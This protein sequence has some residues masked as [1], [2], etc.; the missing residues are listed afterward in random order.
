MADRQTSI[1]RFIGEVE[2]QVGLGRATEPTHYP[3]LKELMEALKSNIT[4]T[5]NPKRVECGAPDFVIDRGNIT[6]GYVEAKK[7]GTSLD[8]IEKSEQLLRYRHSLSNL[9][10]TDFLEFRRYVDGEKRGTARLG[11]IGI[12]G[13]VKQD[14]SGG[15][16]VVE[17]LARFLDEPAVVVGT[18]KELAERMARLTHMIREL[19][20]A[21]FDNETEAGH[22]HGQLAAFQENLIPDLAKVPFSDMYAQTMAYG[23]FAA[24]ATNAENKDFSRKNAANLLPRTNPFL[25]R[26]FNHIAEELDDRIAWLVD[27]LAQLLARSD[28]ASILDE[29]GKRVAKEDPVVHFYETFLKVYDPTLRDLRGVYYTP[30]PVVSYIVRSVDYLLKTTFGRSEG[31]GDPTTLI[32]DPAVGTGTFLYD[33]VKEIHKATLKQGQAG[34]WGNYVSEKLLSRL[35]GF[36]LLMA[37]YAV[38]HF[39]LGL[40]LKETG[41][42]FE[43]AKRLGIYLTNTLEE[44]IKSSQ[45]IFATW[46]SEEANSAAEIKQDRPIMVVLG[47]PPYSVSSQNRGAWID[48][49]LQDYKKGLDEKKLNIDNDYIKFLRFAQWRIEQTGHGILGFITDNS[50]L[51][52]LTHRRMRECL[53]NTFSDIYILNLHGNSR[54]KDKPPDNSRDQNVFEI[55]EGVAIAIFVKE[56]N[57]ESLGRLHY[58]DIW[59]LQKSKYATLSSTA[60]QDTDWQSIEPSGPYFFFVPKDFT[61]NSEYSVMPSLKDIFTFFQNG[62]KTDRDELF[63]DFDPRSLEKR[64]Q[65]FFTNDFDESFRRKYRILRSSSFDIERRRERASFD[66]RYVNPCLYRPFDIR[67]LYYDVVLTSRPA[68]KIMRHMLGGNNIGLITTKQTKDEWGLLATNM[69]CGHKSVAA[70]D[71]NS[72]FPLYLYPSEQEVLSGLYKADERMANIRPDFISELEKRLSMPFDFDGHSKHD[73]RFTAEDIFHYVYAV[74]HSPTYRNR[75]EEFLK[76]DFPRIP[77][78]SNATLFRAL[79]DRGQ[80]RSILRKYP[81]VS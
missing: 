33:A 21:T 10:L 69:L 72:V 30:E 76:I 55:Q 54:W 14:A 18:S 62:I 70:Y 66:S 78:T 80:E 49:L 67:S 15:V 16:S 61:R 52:G 17:L 34:A 12:D 9:I 41:Y 77:L 45:Q 37:P 3:A 59:G 64:M 1:R 74:L 27:D 13:R 47:N 39:K 36:E 29:F 32:L 79:A 4:A 11:S 2:K 53:L 48:T 38:A 23:L 24:R 20:L 46:I 43:D 28:M 44:A 7:V 6:V 50:Y 40:L 31:L 68:H 75:Y 19:I 42:T 5:T 73:G 71:I 63:F 60:V 26:L 51:D 58:A 57:T 65:N 8:A 22:L 56:P 25:R 81:T 35:F